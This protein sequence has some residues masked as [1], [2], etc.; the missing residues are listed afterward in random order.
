MSDITVPGLGEK[1]QDEKLGAYLRRARLAA[2]IDL[3]D[4]ARKIRIAPDILQHI[5]E[6]KWDIFPVEAYVRGYLNSICIHLELDRSKVLGWFGSEYHSDYVMPIAALRNVGV[7]QPTASTNSNSKLIPAL[8][9]VL[10]VVFFV[11]MNL[12]RN[13]EKNEPVPPPV[14]DTNQ[15]PAASDSQAVAD[16]Q[17]ALADSLNLSDTLSG[18]TMATLAQDSAASKA[19]IDTASTTAPAGAPQET[20]L[21]VECLRDSV[22]VRVKRSGEKTKTYQVKQ[23]S[24]RYFS[25]TD[26]LKLRIAAPERTR[27]Y[28]N[29][30]R[31]RFKD[32]KDLTIYNGKL[33]KAEP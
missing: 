16:S 18:D 11:V 23:G 3:N 28:I 29:E 22:W 27:I 20:S 1:G 9:V 25:H 6:S 15:L 32:N 33:I 14:A 4:L 10:I 24:P 2:K 12:L 19:K 7:V 30:E 8:I 17:A 21:R 13:S 5:E 31:V 26:T